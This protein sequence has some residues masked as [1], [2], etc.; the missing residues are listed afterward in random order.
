MSDEK[1]L[2]QRN[3][4]RPEF[5]SPWVGH[6]GEAGACLTTWWDP[7]LT[8]TASVIIIVILISPGFP[9]LWC[10]KVTIT[11]ETV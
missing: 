3:N 9:G 4:K 7:H 8:I 2:F 6:H 10:H 11:I 1:H 5:S